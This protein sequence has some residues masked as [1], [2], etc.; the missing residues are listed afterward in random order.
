MT[1]H[2][3]PGRFEP[4]RD[5]AAEDVGAAV[6]ALSAHLEEL[7]FIRAEI[8]GFEQRTG[9]VVDRAT[10]GEMADLIAAGYYADEAFGVVAGDRAF[11]AAFGDQQDLIDDHSE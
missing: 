4:E 7:R 8:R 2:H 9:R 5:Y 11:E 1:E 10:A 3:H 6:D